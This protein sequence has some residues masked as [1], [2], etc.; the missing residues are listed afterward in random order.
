MNTPTY[1]AALKNVGV[2]SITELQNTPRDTELTV[3]R[4]INRE[5]RRLLTFIDSEE[6]SYRTAL[7]RIQE[8]VINAVAA[9]DGGQTATSMWL[10]AEVNKAREAETRLYSAFHKLQEIA[11][12]RQLILEGT[13]VQ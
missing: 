2:K 1:E 5:C 10:V 11:Y 4:E 8:H 9:L 12:L 6:R 13:P 3:L 7:A